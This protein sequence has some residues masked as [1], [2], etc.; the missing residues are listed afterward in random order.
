[1]L[2]IA[3]SGANIHLVR[4]ATP[5]M[6]RV[7]M[8]NEMKARLPDESTMEST[9][10]ATLQLPCLSRIARQIHIFPKIQTTPLISLGVLCYNG[11][12]ITLGKQTV[13]IQKNGK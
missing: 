7:I 11:C 5:T 6:A 12:T 8:N 2:A 13:S 1:M 9:H 10:I 3:D 4:Q